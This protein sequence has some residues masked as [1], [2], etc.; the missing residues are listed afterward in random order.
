MDTDNSGTLQLSEIR[1]AFQGLNMSEQELNGIF[2]RIDF[3][4]DGEINYTEFL[5][6]TVDRRR[7]IT[8]ANMT[9]AF[10]HF[11]RDNTGFICEENLQECFRREGKH[12]THEDLQAMLDQ[13]TTATPGKITFEE[14]KTFMADIVW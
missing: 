4:H 6:V 14:F 12:L 9:F 2:E 13:V 7:A 11:D 10:H 8:D 1:T 3:N 5:A